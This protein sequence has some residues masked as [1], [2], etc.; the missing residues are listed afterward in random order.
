[1]IVI[2]D[3]HLGYEDALEKQGIALPLNS[4]PRIKKAIRAMRKRTQATRVL[5]NGDLKHEFGSASEQEWTETRDLLRYLRQ[6]FEET[7]VVRGNHDNYLIPI[8][9]A[10]D[11]RLYDPYYEESGHLFLHG[12]KEFLDLHIGEAEVVFFGHEH[13][14]IGLGEGFGARTKFKAILAGETDRGTIVILPVLCPLMGGNILNS[15]DQ[16]ALSPMLSRDD[17]DQ[18]EAIVV[19]KEAGVYRFPKLSHLS[20]LRSTD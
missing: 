4:Y 17:L 2:S 13:P 1:M 12:H 14:A 8:L 5:I 20:R 6:E 10:E 19:N 7:I 9:R 15:P 16:P 11:V 18:L 3:L